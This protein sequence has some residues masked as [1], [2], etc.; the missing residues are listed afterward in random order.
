MERGRER[1]G[2][3]GRERGERG[4]ESEGGNGGLERVAEGR[5]RVR[6]GVEGGQLTLEG[7]GRVWRMGFFVAARWQI[8]V[9]LRDPH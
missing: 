5:G 2:E 9:F 3:K 4:I 6:M 1:G 8:T 7:W